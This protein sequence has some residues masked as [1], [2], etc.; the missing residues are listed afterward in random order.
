M[1]AAPPPLTEIVQAVTPPLLLVVKL[2]AI[3]LRPLADAVPPVSAG[4]PMVRATVDAA[5]PGPAALTAF[6]VTLTGELSG[7]PVS[8]ADVPVTVCVVPPALTWYPVTARPLFAAGCQATWMA[9]L[10]SSGTGVS[11][12]GAPGTVNGTTVL[13]NGDGFDDVPRLLTAATMNAYCVP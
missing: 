4:G 11:P 7:N 3:A 6:T 1:P 2:T 10:A 12:F 5:A 9:P 13:D 8:C